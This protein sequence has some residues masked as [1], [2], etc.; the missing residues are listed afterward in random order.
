VG[1]VI[2]KAEIFAA[3]AECDPNAI[4]MT[5]LYKAGIVPDKQK[6]RKP[7]NGRMV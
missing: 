7:L 2:S 1:L 5:P 3:F 6:A 4:R